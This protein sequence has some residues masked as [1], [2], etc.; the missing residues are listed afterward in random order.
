MLCFLLQ[1][2]VSYHKCAL[3]KIYRYLLLSGGLELGCC[4]FFKK[5]K[6]QNKIFTHV[7]FKKC[8][9]FV[10]DLQYKLIQHFPYVLLN[11][12]NLIYL[13]TILFNNVFYTIH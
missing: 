1:E 2:K 11:V 13:N 8:I 7:I 4:A 6:K 12:T 3:L 10:N 9:L 5:M